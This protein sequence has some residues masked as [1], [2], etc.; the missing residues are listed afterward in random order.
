MRAEVKIDGPTIFVFL[1]E[2]REGW[3]F[4]IENDSDYSFSFYQYVELNRLMCL[5]LSLMY[6]PGPKPRQCTAKR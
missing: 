3:P 6:P 5:R 1:D 4:R 2:A